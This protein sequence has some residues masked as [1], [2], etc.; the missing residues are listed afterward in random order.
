M[1]G[2]RQIPRNPHPT[3]NRA[4]AK[5][6]NTIPSASRRNAPASGQPLRLVRK[7]KMILW[8]RDQTSPDPR[9]VP[10]LN[11]RN[12]RINA[13][14]GNPATVEASLETKPDEPQRNATRPDVCMNQDAPIQDAVPKAVVGVPFSDGGNNRTS[15]IEKIAPLLTD[16]AGGTESSRHFKLQPSEWSEPAPFTIEI[17]RRTKTMPVWKGLMTPADTTPLR[18]DQE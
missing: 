15:T 2:Q 12:P 8:A 14:R 17:K 7:A 16:I 10:R 13:A 1:D 4:R 11:R 9:A 18:T 3:R 6:R 5:H